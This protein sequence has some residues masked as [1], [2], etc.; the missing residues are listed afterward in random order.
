MKKESLIRE[1]KELASAVKCR[2]C[3]TYIWALISSL[4]VYC[5]EFQS[6]YYDKIKSFYN[7]DNSAFECLYALF[8]DNELT[9]II[10]NDFGLTSDLYKFRIDVIN[11][12]CR[13]RST[14]DDDSYNLIAHAALR[15]EI[16]ESFESLVIL[17]KC[18]KEG[19][20]VSS[21]FV[22]NFTE[23]NKVIT[24]LNSMDFSKDTYEKLFCNTNRVNLIFY[25]YSDNFKDRLMTS[26]VDILENKLFSN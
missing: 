1:I 12:S 24:L 25:G 9:S 11:N 14:K 23:S 4:T 21:D 18:V 22:S 26:V 3:P 7:K 17:H 10:Q 20:T 19:L 16:T 8:T 6:A 2:P 5:Y 15:L 13:F